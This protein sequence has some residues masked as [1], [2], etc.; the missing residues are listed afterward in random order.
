MAIPAGVNQV[1]ITVGGIFGSLGSQATVTGT[2]KPVFGG[3]VKSVVWEANGDTYSDVKEDVLGESGV[4]ASFAVVDPT[5]DGWVI[6]TPNGLQTIKNWAYLFEGRA[7][8]PNGSTHIISKA[9]QI[10]AGQTTIDLDTVPDGQVSSGVVAPA[11]GVSSVNGQTGA[12]VID[13]G[14]GTVDP[15]DVEAIVADYLLANPA[16]AGP[17]GPVGPTGEQGP[18]GPTGP[19]GPKGDTG[20]QGPQ[21]P[22]GPVGPAG[23]QGPPGADGASGGGSSTVTLDPAPN[24]V[25]L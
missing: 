11:V 10:T 1:L 14:G 20:N 2:L 21:G 24:V 22:Q 16:P 9:F 17:Q 7:T 18:I 15:E 6:P 13:V 3:T 4:A 5:Q 8:F 25:L 23:P 19:Q 12:V